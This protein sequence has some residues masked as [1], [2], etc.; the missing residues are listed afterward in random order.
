DGFRTTVGKDR[1]VRLACIELA[2]DDPVERGGK[3][4]GVWMVGELCVYRDPR[5]E[6]FFRVLDYLWM[7]VSEDQRS[8][9]A[10]VVENRNCFLALI[11][12]VQRVS[13]GANV[14]DVKPEGGQQITQIRFCE[15][16]FESGHLAPASS[17]LASW[18]RSRRRDCRWRSA[19]CGL[20]RGVARQVRHLPGVSAR[21]PRS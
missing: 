9:T 8:V 2:P 21:R 17:E 4:I 18:L 3:L 15:F 1:Q 13:F 19:T 12:I 7:V 16:V 6:E 20:H 14:L 10:D 11:K 5:V